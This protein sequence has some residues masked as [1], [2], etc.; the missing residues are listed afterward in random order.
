[1]I[2]APPVMGGKISGGWVNFTL[3]IDPAKWVRIQLTLT[4][5]RLN[6]E[7]KRRTLVVRIF[8]N[9]QSCLRLIRALAVE[10]H[11]NWLEQHRYLNMEE[12]REHKKLMMRQAA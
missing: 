6:E 1:M 11:E 3:T 10:T 12:L 2:T 4:L 7:I 5:E 9:A 8:P